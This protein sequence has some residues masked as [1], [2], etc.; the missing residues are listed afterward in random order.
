LGF[1]DPMRRGLP[2]DDLDGNVVRAAWRLLKD[3]SND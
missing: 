3:E 1:P 2:L